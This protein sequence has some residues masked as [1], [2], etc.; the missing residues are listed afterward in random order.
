[1]QIEA[2]FLSQKELVPTEPAP[3]IT[4]KINEINQR[5]TESDHNQQE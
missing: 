1:M 4:C 3:H 2:E 5:S